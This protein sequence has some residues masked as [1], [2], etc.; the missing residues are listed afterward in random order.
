MFCAYGSFAQYNGDLHAS[1][2]KGRTVTLSETQK[3]EDGV[4]MR[5]GRM[6]VV[7]KGVETSMYEDVSLLDG[8]RVHID[9]TLLRVDGTKNKL[10]ND[11]RIN[12]NGVWSK[13]PALHYATMQNGR[14][15]LVR[16]TTSILMDREL[17]TENGNKIYAQGYVVTVDGR[18]VQFME[19]DRM[20]ISGAW[21]DPL[22]MQTTSQQL[23]PVQK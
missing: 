10:H 18:R 4:L 9:G 3:M 20:N 23:E 13:L 5:N 19:G 17:V 7:K 12:I 14:M 8:T 2:A 15:M 6:Y 21:M 1:P 11:E 16:D 22:P